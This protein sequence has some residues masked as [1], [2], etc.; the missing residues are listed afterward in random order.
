MA[1]YQ[2]SA[3]EKFNFRNPGSWQTWLQ[4][5]ERFRSASKLSQDSDDRQIDSLIYAMGEQ[6]EDILK[7]LSL[8]DEQ[9]KSYE[10]VK[11]ALTEHFVVR[12]NVI[13]ERA[14]F[15]RRV[16]GPDES[17]D[18]FITALHTLAETC[19]YGDL[20]DQLI[21]DRLVVGLKDLQ[22]SE[23]LQMD[24]K[25]TLA[26]ATKQARESER[27][28]GQQSSLRVQPP[29]SGNVDA[30]RSRFKGGKRT[31]TDAK[32]TSSQSGFKPSHKQKSQPGSGNDTCKWCGKGFHIRRDCPA[33]NA[34]CRHCHNV[35]HYA[36][37][38]MRRK[39]RL[40]EVDS[41]Q[42]PGGG[43]YFLGAVEGS[44]PTGKPLT[45]RIGIGMT[46]LEFKL[47]T[48][49][50]VTAIPASTHEK[51]GVIL[52]K[53]NRRLYG[54][55][56]KELHVKGTFTTRLKTAHMSA[57]CEVFVVDGLHMPLLGRPAIEQ[58]GLVSYHLDAIRT[59]DDIRRRHPR[60]AR[61]LGDLTEPYDAVLSDNA[62]PYVET[63]PRRIPI[64]LAPKVKPQLDRMEELG[65]IRPVKEP[66]DW[67]AGIIVVPKKDGSVRICVDLTH[68]NSSIKRERLQL[69]SEQETLSQLAGAQ[70]FSK[71][72]AANSFWMIPLTERTQLLTTFI[73]PYGRYCFRRLPFGISSATEQFQRRMQ[74]CLVGA[75]GVIIRTDDVLVKGNT[76]EEH[77]QNLDKALM[78]LDWAGVALNLSKCV[79]SQSAVEYWGH[80]VSA[81][82]IQPLQERTSAV[83][84]MPAPTDTT[85]IRRFLGMA[86]QLGKF[87]KELAEVSAPLRELLKKDRSWVWGTAQEEAFQKIKTLLC[88]TNHILVFYDIKR[89]TVV[90]ADASAHGLGA[91]LLQRQDDGA[92][93]PVT[94]ASRALTPT[95]ERYAQI[96]KEAL[97]V[98]WACERFFDY[99]IGLDTFIIQSDHKPLIPLLGG[100]K[101]LVDM[102]PRI[103][104]F[105]MRLMRYNYQ[106]VHVPGKELWTADALSRAPAH[107]SQPS[108]ADT[109]LLEDTNVYVDSIVSDSPA[110]QGKLR[111]IQIM[112]EEDPVCRVLLSYVRNGWPTKHELPSLLKPYWQHQNELTLVR[113]LLLRGTRIVIPSD[114]RLEMLERLHQGH[115]G[116]VR[117]RARAPQSI[118]WPGL[119]HQ[120]EDMIKSCTVCV[121]EQSMPTEPLNPTTFPERPWQRLGSDLFT[122][123]GSTYLT[124][125]DYFSRYVEMAYLK[126]IDSK[127]TINQLQSIFARHGVPD[128]FI[129][130]N[131]PQYDSAEFAAFARDYNFLH[132]TS[133]PRYPK[134][135][136][137]AERSVQTLK[138]IIH[139]CE[140]PYKALL[141][142]R[143]TP[144]HNGYSPAQLL[145]GRQ[146]RTNLPVMEEQLYPKWPDFQNLRQGEDAY[147]ANYKENYDRRHRAAELPPLQ[148]GTQVW[149][150]DMKRPGVVQQPHDT[151]RSYLIN[152]Q[153]GVLRRNRAHLIVEPPGSPTP[154]PREPCD[155]LH[156]LP[157]QR[158]LPVLVS[159]QSPAPTR[160]TRSNNVNEA[161]PTPQTVKPSSSTHSRYGREFK[162]VERM[163][164]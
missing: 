157:T 26:T 154:V 48:G 32:K 64:P 31:P 10:A 8:T 16:Q 3:P 54:A 164:V 153:G 141:Q 6:A 71:L 65:V 118:W 101:P 108:V 21:R 116:I 27:I 25:L 19:E 97:A 102:P 87:C 47:D 92:L 135:N 42:D 63:A 77:D 106:I 1:S 115:Q 46:E 107:T 150:K 105:R 40:D 18:T 88:S 15:N 145:F 142:H 69:P 76:Q 113:G 131:G 126:E 38:C 122:Y 149:V 41:T 14:V 75:E 119:S 112:Q 83:A 162:K 37:V 67:C 104:R 151:P 80:R 100:A 130:D 84:D 137:E 85:E 74:E 96:E 9:S 163:D 22:L 95:E 33:R 152:S 72:D 35:G 125:V 61:P 53:S 140:D 147:R 128:E 114:L 24:S 78:L 34:K 57:L 103:Q 55:G 45:A 123:R 160:T 143:A 39:Q 144:L 82:G 91:T 58:L 127:H 159:P 124:V 94:Y 81:E 129:S 44:S 139:K 50:D 62:Q 68:L 51:L 23:R 117:T 36:A 89:E 148:P 138:S 73:T 98:T 156:Q 11:K 79:I 43:T 70:V 120:I 29:V 134:S 49:A 161:L 4:R 7:S 86:N 13:F 93:R 12:R 90:S 20:K 110:S 52:Q 133:S 132:V 56:R 59:V 155:D 109:D 136:G 60:L 30:M 146:I 17:V 158:S 5:F 111:E 2:L 121:R 28:K 66:T 99:L